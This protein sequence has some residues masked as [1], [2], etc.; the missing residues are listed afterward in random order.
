[1]KRYLLFG[2]EIYYPSG[3][4]KD[5]L[6]S[7]DSLE[8]LMEQPV[9]TFID[10]LHIVD[11]S[12]DGKIVRWWCKGERSDIAAWYDEEPEDFPV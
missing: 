10:W 11:T 2:G 7:A 9:E 5:L 6:G 12:N 4:W 8:E 3:G 1:M